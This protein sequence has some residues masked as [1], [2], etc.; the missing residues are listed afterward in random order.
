MIGYVLKDSEGNYVSMTG[1]ATTD[2]FKASKFDYEGIKSREMYLKCGYEL[3]SFEVRESNKIIV[4]ECGNYCSAEFD[5]DMRQDG[6]Y[7]VCQH[8][9]EE[10]HIIN[11]RGDVLL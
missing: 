10:I 5:I 6:F 2:W 11:S 4:C 1:G 9:K 8:C 3:Y 7:K